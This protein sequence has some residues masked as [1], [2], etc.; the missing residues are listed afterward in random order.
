MS[1]VSGGD[2]VFNL[3]FK[4]HGKQV[5][6]K[7]FNVTGVAKACD[8][9]HKKYYT[10]AYPSSTSVNVHSNFYGNSDYTVSIPTTSIGIDSYLASSFDLLLPSGKVAHYD[11]D[12]E[13]PFIDEGDVVTMVQKRDEKTGKPIVYYVYN[14]NSKVGRG[15][16]ESYGDLGILYYGSGSGKKFLAWTVGS[17]IMYLILLSANNNLAWVFSIPIVY[18][19][20]K[21]FYQKNHDKKMLQKAQ[22]LNSFFDD[23]ARN[24]G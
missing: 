14:Q 13:T 18:T 21:Y 7:L 12:S 6:L 4:N 22:K 10:Y 20:V 17:I 16:N 24:S 5:S 23:F 19:G 9:N 15:V 8:I 3:P 1:N 2:G 11:L